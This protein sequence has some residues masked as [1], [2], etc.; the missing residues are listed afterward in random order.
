MDIV[1]RKIQLRLASLWLCLGLAQCLSLGLAVAV[2]GADDNWIYISEFLADNTRGLKDEEGTFSGWIEL[3]QTSLA[4]LDLGGWFLTDSRTNL[5]QWRFPRVTLLPGKYVV[6]F[7]SGKNRTT[8]PAHLHTNFRLNPAGGY[9]ALVDRTTNVVSEFAPSYPK[10]AADISFGR[11]MGEAAIR[12]QFLHPT[13]GRVNSSSGPGFA[14]TVVFSRAGGNFTDS[15]RLE[16]GNDSNV[17][18]VIRYTLDGTLPNRTSQIYERPLWITNTVQVRARA[19]QEGLLPGP[20]RSEAYLRL[21]TDTLEFSSNLP[22]LV[23]DTLGTHQPM[24]ANTTFVQLS[25]HEPVQGRSS[26]TNPP[27]WSSRAAFRVRGSTSAGMP[28]QG[29]ALESVDEFNQERPV[30][31]PG[32]PPD[33]DWILYAPNGYDPVLLHNPFVHQLCRDLGRYSPRT[34]FVEVFLTSSRG[35]VHQAHY[36]GLYVLQEKIKIG[37]NRINID[38]L[39]A[40]D[41]KPPQVTGGYL[42]KFDRLGPDEQGFSAAGASIV[43]VEPKEQTIMAP[44][45]AAQRQYLSAFFRDFDR[46]LRGPRWKEPEAGYRAYFDVPAA[47]DFHVLEV[48]S[49]NVDALVFSTFFY[50]PRNGKLAFGPH[51][52]FDRALGSTD[53]RDADPQTWTT[54]PF[55]GGAWWPR[56]FRDPDFWQQW[57]DRWQELRR[58]HFSLAHQYQVIDRMAAELREAQPR[59]YQKWGFQ[60]RGG[61][62]ASEIRHMKDWLSNRVEFI[63]R[64]LVQPPRLSHAGGTVASNLL[65]TISAPPNASVYYTLDGSDP[66]LAQGAIS[67]NAVI[68]TKPIPIVAK[69]QLFARARNPNQRQTDGPPSSTPWS[70]PVTATFDTTRP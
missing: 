22:I 62:Y 51:W 7:A 44:Q 18:A 3:H 66:R 68:Y 14:P 29:F 53:G 20:P 46:A 43:Y 23:M 47:I 9:L 11:V 63:D 1:I 36:N 57:V 40:D 8:D 34:R 17:A 70:G 10:Q 27:T 30:T 13:P 19:Y 25:W 61:S 45:R 4:P 35:R 16:L 52:D 42:F 12:G 31:I 24:S 39:S 48:L 49:G 37:K 65:L 56:L 21:F 28:Q 54:G 26:L 60:P 64:Q 32:L 67:S 2:H 6:I 55:F 50:K 59:Q 69:S 5:T 41:L 33:S 58:T 38:H 15:F